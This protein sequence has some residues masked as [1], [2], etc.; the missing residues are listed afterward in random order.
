MRLHGVADLLPRGLAL[1]AELAPLLGELL[2]ERIAP[3]GGLRH[4]AL[5]VH[6]RPVAE[7]HR[8]LGDLRLQRRELL[9]RRRRVQLLPLP[10]RRGLGLVPRR[11]DL[12][13]PPR[14]LLVVGHA[15]HR[16]HSFGACIVLHRSENVALRQLPPLLQRAA[17]ARALDLVEARRPPR[18]ERRAEHLLVERAGARGLALGAWRRRVRLFHALHLLEGGASVTAVSLEVGYA[19]TSA[20]CQAY[21]RQFGVS[22]GRRTRAR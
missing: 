18:G 16:N 13:V 2:L 3:R 15:R 12:V 10:E 7:R 1:V 9:A 17:R 20:F 8:A 19:S 21:R 11:R 22:P 6:P 14:G 5:G 4:A